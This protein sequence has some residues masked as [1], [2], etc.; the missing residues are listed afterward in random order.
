MQMGPDPFSKPIICARIPEKRNIFLIDHHGYIHPF[1]IDDISIGL[2][3]LGVDPKLLPLLIDLVQANLVYG[4]AEQIGLKPGL[5]SQ[6]NEA[7]RE[8]I[9]KHISYKIDYA[10]H[11]EVLK[12]LLDSWNNVVNHPLTKPF[13]QLTDTV[14]M[15]HFEDEEMRIMPFDYYHVFFK[16]I[17]SGLLNLW[18]ESDTQ[19]MTFYMNLAEVYFSALECR[20]YLRNDFFNYDLLLREL[21]DC[22]VNAAD[23]RAEPLLYFTTEV[24]KRRNWA[25]EN[26]L[27]H[28]GGWCEGELLDLE[29]EFDKRLLEIALINILKRADGI[30][31]IDKLNRKLQDI[32]NFNKYL[33]RLD[34]EH[35]SNIASLTTYVFRTDRKDGTISNHEV[36]RHIHEAIEYTIMKY[37]K[38]HGINIYGTIFKLPKTLK[39][40]ALTEDKIIE[41]LYDKTIC[42]AHQLYALYQLTHSEIIRSIVSALVSQLD[43]PI[44]LGILPVLPSRDLFKRDLHASS[45]KIEAADDNRQVTS[46]CAESRSRISDIRTNSMSLQPP[47]LLRG[48]PLIS[49]AYT[50]MFLAQRQF[51]PGYHRLRKLISGNMITQPGIDSELK[52]ADALA[53]VLVLTPNSN[54]DSNENVESQRRCAIS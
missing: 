4:F 3:F 15:S 45:P 29:R 43:V 27:T 32:Y 20:S 18:K 50:P 39:F 12:I 8:N 47:Y 16:N 44:G 17:F 11:D 53:R 1:L 31:S 6:G 30:S 19:S 10:A 14:E 54:N 24:E 34:E 13:R 49:G 48:I 42:Q 33:Y 38:E 25:Q 41:S 36:E 37:A 23:E 7:I 2:K 52:L 26:C 46:S 40:L 22:R 35:G 9:K 51:T 28:V 5:F 21:R